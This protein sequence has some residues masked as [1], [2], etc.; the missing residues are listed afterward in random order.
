MERPLFPAWSNSVYWLAIGTVASL[1]VGAP[2]LLLAWAR[3]PYAT[4]VGQ[5]VDQPV[6]F[7]HRHHVRDDGIDCLY[8][9]EGAEKSPYAGVPAA[10][11]CMGCHNQ[12]WND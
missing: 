8:C 4:G 3:T 2:L 5:A 1:L 9:H 11:R 7:D 10:D 12:V 6:K